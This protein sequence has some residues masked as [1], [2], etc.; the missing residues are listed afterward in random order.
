MGG[1]GVGGQI[2]VI[3][4]GC[5]NCMITH[6]RKVLVLVMSLLPVLQQNS[7]PDFLVNVCLK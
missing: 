7:Y 5:H 4:C 2:L 1:M 3:F 6:V